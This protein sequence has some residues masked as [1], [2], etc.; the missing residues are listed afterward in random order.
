VSEM[1]HISPKTPGKHRELQRA[2]DAHRLRELVDWKWVGGIW[3]ASARA[4]GINF[5]A[6]SF[7]H[8]DISPFKWNQQFTGGR[9]PAQPQTVT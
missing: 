4:D 8:S 5:Q 2:V 6:C 3:C 1:R 7:N 9:R